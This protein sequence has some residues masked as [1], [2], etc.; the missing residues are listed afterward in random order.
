MKSIL[1]KNYSLIVF[2]V[3]ILI[4]SLFL[5]V[6]AFKYTEP[7]ID[8]SDKYVSFNDYT[9]SILDQNPIKKVTDSVF[10]T[11][12]ESDQQPFYIQMF[13]QGF[14]SAPS[15]A[16]HKYARIPEGVNQFQIDFKLAGTLN[17]NLTV[18]LMFY[19]ENNRLKNDIQT[20]TLLNPRNIEKSH[21]NKLEIISLKSA[22]E[23][24]F[25]YFKVAI[26]VFPPDGKNGFIR[27][28]D[29]NIVYR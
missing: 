3:I 10:I 2:A 1:K 4:I 5:S 14:G 12:W 24:D 16:Y 19:D 11:E 13:D 8:L 20:I 29:L 9:I 6:H 28:E 17:T 15:Q 7:K 22:L 18:F 27:L 25:K 23:S 21:T 26:K